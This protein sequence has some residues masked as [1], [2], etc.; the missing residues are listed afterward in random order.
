MS[1]LGVRLAFAGLIAAVSL[2]PVA[3]AADTVQT[4]TAPDLRSVRAAIKVKHYSEALAE[5][6]TI[7]VKTPHPDVYS[8]MG[9]TLRKTGDRPQ[10]M[11]YYQ[12]ALAADPVHKGALEYQGELFVEMG[13][14]D[15]AKE[16]LAKLHKLCVFG[17]EEETD[18]KEAIAHAP[19][20]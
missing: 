15:K 11:V 5:L 20:A 2:A 14:I 4:D 13:Q 10:A 9:F 3:Y 6:K 12:K 1:T 18:L 19:R 17:C 8:L 7:E 16:N